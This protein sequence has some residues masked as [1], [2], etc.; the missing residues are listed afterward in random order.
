MYIHS[1]PNSTLKKKKTIYNDESK[2]DY[3]HLYTNEVWKYSLLFMYVFLKNCVYLFSWV[4]SVAQLCSTLCNPME[5]HQ[6]S[7]SIT[8]S[9][10]LLKLMSIESLM[11]SNHI[12]CCPLILLPSIFPSIRIFSSVSVLCIR[13]PKYWGFIFSISPSNEYSELISFR[14]D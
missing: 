3:I 11:P 9:R 1:P 4:S 8:K 7:L 14:M 10:S 13:W 12:F 5:A 6:A 2:L